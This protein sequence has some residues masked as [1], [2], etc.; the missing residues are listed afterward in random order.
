MELY[1]PKKSAYTK[2][3]RRLSQKPPPSQGLQ[4]KVMMM[5]D[6]CADRQTDKHRQTDRHTDR[7]R[8]RQ[9]KTKTDEDGQAERQRKKRDRQREY[10]V[11]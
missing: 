1:E 7:K 9:T 10:G 3:I 5:D 8:Q 2:T 6:K 11:M 4:S